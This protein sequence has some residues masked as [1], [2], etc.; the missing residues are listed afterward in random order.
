MNDCWKHS[1][2]ICHLPILLLICWNVSKLITSYI[3]PYATINAFTLLFVGISSAYGWTQS[4]IFKRKEEC[5]SCPEFSWNLEIEN[6]LILHQWPSEIHPFPIKFAIKSNPLRNYFFGVFHVFNV[7][8][9]FHEPFSF[10]NY[11][12]IGIFNV[13]KNRLIHQVAKISLP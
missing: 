13:N 11:Q 3:V 1:H 8:S 5:D 9:F 2:I 7:L 4:L 6:Q 12:F 10:Q